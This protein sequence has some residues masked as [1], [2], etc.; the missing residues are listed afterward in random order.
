MRL[1]VTLSGYITRQFLASIVMVFVVLLGLVFLIDSVELLRRT[2]NRNQAGMGTIIEMALLR[3]P[4]MSQKIIP[5]AVLFGGML[6]L[7]RLTRSNELVVA[8]ASGVSVWQFLLPGLSLALV[9]GGLIITLFNPL[10][11]AT[12]WRYEQLEAKYMRGQTSLLAVSSSGLWLREAGESGQTVVHALRISQEE[13]TLHDTTFFLYEGIDQ[14]ARRIDAETAT[15]EDGYWDLKNV[16]ISAPN[17]ITEARETFRL[18]TSMTINQIQESF[19][20]PETMSFWNLPGFIET[21]EAA[22]FSAIK[23]RIHW[24]SILAIPML[25]CAMVLIA[26]TFSLRLT[27][28]GGTGLLVVGGLFAGF[29]LFFMTDVVL[30]LG[31]S[32]SIPVILAAW[33]PA[34]VFTL[35]GLAML[36]HLEDG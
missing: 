33:A 4:F 21:L 7:T 24:H 9:I 14:F 18:D 1:S 28:R 32:G 31:M 20:P 36:L 17:K 13:M 11:S 30:A 27:R 34:G 8:R 15:L 6:S 29:F 19:A 5:F 26:A 3:I 23:H 22:G 16:L 35:L 2:G 10:A 12:T 25:L